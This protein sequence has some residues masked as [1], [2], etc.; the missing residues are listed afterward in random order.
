MRQLEDEVFLYC[1]DHEE[2]EMAGLTAHFGTP[3]EVANNFLTELAPAVRWK[4]ERIR[5]RV[6]YAAIA[7]VLAA[8]L[9]V[10]AM[11]GYTNIKQQK[12]LD[13]HYIESITYEGDVAPYVTGPTY[14]VEHFS[15]DENSENIPEE[16]MD[17][18]D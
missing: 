16:N 2:M 17:W 18:G 3:E 12:I 6:F 14:A 11:E 9:L 15:S 1:E 8:A 10:T 13:G 4:Y 5:Q 7:I